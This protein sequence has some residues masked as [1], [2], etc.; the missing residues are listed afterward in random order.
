MSVTA[1][2]SF[3]A[4][5][6]IYKEEKPFRFKYQPPAG[7]KETNVV[8]EDC[9]VL[10]RDIREHGADVRIE[11]QGFALYPF[12]TAMA[13]ED[14]EHYERIESVYLKEVAEFLKKELKASRVQ[15]TDHVV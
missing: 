1:T 8:L 13:Y 4:N 7:V 5:D 15:V 6:P 3:L 10:V 12:K 9:E 2:I 11:E 14:F